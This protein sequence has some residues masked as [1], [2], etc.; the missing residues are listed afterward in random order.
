ELF[1]LIELEENDRLVLTHS[2]PA[3]ILTDGMLLHLTSVYFHTD[4]GGFTV[5]SVCNTCL[6]YL[7]RDKTPPLSLANGMWIGKVP[8]ELKI[9]TLPE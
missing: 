4:A 5:V 9:L 3:H 2:L 1:R 6:S 8:A 7:H